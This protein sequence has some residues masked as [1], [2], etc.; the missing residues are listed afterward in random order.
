M[1]GNFGRNAHQCHGQAHAAEVQTPGAGRAAGLA[2]GRKGL[3]EGGESIPR[4]VGFAECLLEHPAAMQ[5][6]S[7]YLSRGEWDGGGGAVCQTPFW[8]GVQPSHMPDTHQGNRGWGS[9]EGDFG[10]T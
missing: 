4:K 10:Y 5:I 3:T 7:A 9:E 6:G 8:L 1:Q 2:G